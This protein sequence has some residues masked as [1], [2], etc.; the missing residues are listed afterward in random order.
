[1]IKKIL[2]ILDQKHKYYCLILLLI[3][4]PVTFIETIGISSIPA[5]VLIITQPDELGSYISN[6]EIT[7]LILN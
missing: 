2:K 1:M 7:N 4:L 5:F 6:L 3:F